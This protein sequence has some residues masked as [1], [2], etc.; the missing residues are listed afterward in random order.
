MSSYDEYVE[1]SLAKEAYEAGQKMSKHTP[2]PWIADRLHPEFHTKDVAV[3]YVDGRIEH[4]GFGYRQEIC[5]LYEA[6]GEQGE[7]NAKLIA[8]APELLEKAQAVLA[9]WDK[10]LPTVTHNDHPECEDAEWKEFFEL[11]RVVEQATT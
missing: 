9:W 3:R 4:V 6:R 5:T 1:W 2:G 10:W 8:A 7:A 11:R